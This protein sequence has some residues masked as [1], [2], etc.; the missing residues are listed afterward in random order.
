MYS[1]Q[2]S[3]HDTRKRRVLCILY[4]VLCIIIHTLWALKHK[5][6]IHEFGEFSIQWNKRANSTKRI[7]N[8]TTLT[9][10][11]V[12]HDSSTIQ[13]QAARSVASGNRENFPILPQKPKF[14]AKQG[15][16]HSPQ[17]AMRIVRK[18]SKFSLNFSK[19]ILKFLKNFQTFLTHLNFSIK[20]KNLFKL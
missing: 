15:K 5:R 17:P 9:W 8:L 14:F 10:E 7:N 1:K 4:R 2:G 3:I 16:Q 19:I 13:S 12:I 20:F 18:N 11:L 6:Y